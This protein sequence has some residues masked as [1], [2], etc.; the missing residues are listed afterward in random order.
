MFPLRVCLID[1][2]VSFLFS[3]DVA[4]ILFIIVLVVNV[5]FI[6][7][8]DKTPGLN[9]CFYQLSVERASNG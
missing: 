6:I 2:I 4:I 1:I 3:D 7:V 5:L 9:R 8:T